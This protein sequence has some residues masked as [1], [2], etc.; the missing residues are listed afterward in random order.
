MQVT[1][2]YLNKIDATVLYSGRHVLIHTYKVILM[3]LIDN[4][5]ADI[6]HSGQTGPRRAE[7]RG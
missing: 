3:F 6:K 4:Q 7:V 5:T 2:I 1:N